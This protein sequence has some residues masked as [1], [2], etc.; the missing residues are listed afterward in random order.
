MFCDIKYLLQIEKGQSKPMKLNSQQQRSLTDL[1]DIRNKL[2]ETVELM[3][4][5]M[6]IMLRTFPK[7]NIDE[8]MTPKWFSEPVKVIAAGEI[9]NYQS[10]QTAEKLAIVLDKHRNEILDSYCGRSMI[11][12]IDVGFEY[13]LTFTWKF[14]HLECLWLIMPAA[15]GVPNV[16]ICCATIKPSEKPKT[17][18]IFDFYTAISEFE[19]M[20]KEYEDQLKHGANE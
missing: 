17:N 4:A 16:K 11:P 7:L 1:T 6:N 8:K 5:R 2:E 20:Q 9:V 18:Y 10:T 14:R 12:T 3:D 13:C 19:K 15:L